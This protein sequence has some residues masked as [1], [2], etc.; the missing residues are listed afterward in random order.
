MNRFLSPGNWVGLRHRQMLGR[1]PPAL[2]GEQAGSVYNVNPKHVVLPFPHLWQTT[3]LYAVF[4]FSKPP[5]VSW[6]SKCRFQGKN[7]QMEGHGGLSRSLCLGSEEN[8]MCLPRYEK[9]EAPPSGNNLQLWILISETNSR[10]LYPLRS[11]V[12]WG[13]Y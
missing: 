6:M 2:F 5:G 8:K 9:S 12:V 13:L 7:E 10:A 11:D 1:G 4:L 3:D